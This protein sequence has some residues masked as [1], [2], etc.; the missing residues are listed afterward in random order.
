MGK[1]KKYGN[2]FNGELLAT[3]AFNIFRDGGYWN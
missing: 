3:L 1:F 2:M